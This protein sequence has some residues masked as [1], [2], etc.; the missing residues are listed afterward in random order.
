VL[1]PGATIGDMADPVLG[2]KERLLEAQLQEV[3]LRYEAALPEDRVQAEMLRSQI[4]YFAS[5]LQ[6]ARARLHALKLTTPV[7]GTFLVNT[8]EDL[9]GRFERRGDL[10]GYA[11]DGSAAIVRVIVPQADIALVRDDTRGI[12]LRFASDP[13]HVLH[14]AHALREIPTA[15]R[16]LPSEALA[17]VGG[18]P[19]ELDP[20]DDKHQRALEVVFQLDV[21]LPEGMQVHRIGERVYVRFRHEDRSIGWRI[22][23]SA[24]QLFLKRFDL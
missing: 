2:A 6:D 10:I 11:F 13:M 20:A 7:A 22:A 14:V 17:T 24:R 23:R 19:F 5:G 4:A 15:T 9:P 16:E 8:P 3:R 18:G 12:E 1:A 21:K